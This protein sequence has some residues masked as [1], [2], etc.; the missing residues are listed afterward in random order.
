MTTFVGPTPFELQDRRLQGRVAELMGVI[1]AATAQLVDAVEE[2]I[3]QGIWNV[4]GVRSPEQWVMWRAGVSPGRAQGLVRMARRRDDLPELTS[5]FERGALT[6]DA[7]RIIAAKVPAER[8]GEVA[9][10]APQLLQS[11]LR[12][13]LS[14]LPEVQHAQGRAGA[15]AG[16]GAVD[17]LRLSR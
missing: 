7:M 6:E 16:A 2:V 9:R 15:E 17:A 12:R 1:N 13:V 3:E 5:L 14:C 10:L 4:P 11:Q 8:D